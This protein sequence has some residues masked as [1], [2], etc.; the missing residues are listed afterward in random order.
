MT[1]PEPHW[2]TP[3]ADKPGEGEKSEGKPRRHRRSAWAVLLPIVVLL[4]LAAL[5]AYAFRDRLLPGLEV[6]F[7]EAVA[8]SS[9]SSNATVD[10]PA[11]GASQLL[12][13]ASGWIE[14][15]PLPIRAVSL[16]S[17]VVREMHVLEGQSVTNGQVLATLVDDDARLVLRH[18]GARLA[19]ARAEEA[20][21]HAEMALVRA[22]EITATRKYEGESARLAEL[23]DVTRRLQA[24]KPGTIPER[25]LV[26]A[27]L[28]ERTQSSA[29]ATAEATI[30]EWKAEQVR[31]Q[32]QVLVQQ[33]LVVAAKVAGEEAQLALSRTRVLAPIDGVVL[34][35][36]ATPG[37]R[38]MLDMDM[39]DSATAAILYEPGKLQ[40]RVDVPLADAGKLAV[41]QVV[42]VTCSLL[43]DREFT[44]TVT[45]IVGEA[46]LQRNTLQAKVRI[47]NPDPR[48]RPEMLCR[49]EFF[50]AGQGS[51][52]ASGSRESLTIFVPAEVVLNRSGKAAQVWVLS[53]DGQ[54]AK[55][56]EVTLGTG[57]PEGYPSVMEGLRP[58]DRVIVN[59]PASLKEGIRIKA[60][61]SKI[62]MDL[63][64]P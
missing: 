39:A 30:G 1:K 63:R 28:R 51:S 34:R 40:A 33:Q 48:L 26:Q 54:H 57:R 24:L 20:A 15:D 31:L 10:K 7:V 59:P 37:K 38:L 25:D 6:E 12:F 58:G 62:S 23:T 60:R 55:R 19:Q 43:P 29:V 45:R 49:G 22:R 47:T 5:F 32:K 61:K 53:A 41:G 11:S 35:L 18:T 9:G 27:Q 14:P 17:G 8:L 36:L 64:T 42:R 56:R 21:L 13:Q 2:L 4:G 50:G 46:D 44:G 52:T 3:K 16:Y